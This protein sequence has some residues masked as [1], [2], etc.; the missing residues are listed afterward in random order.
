M[1]FVW[2]WEQT[3]IISLY[4]INWLVFIIETEC[5]YCAVRTG[6]LYVIQVFCFSVKQLT[7]DIFNS[8]FPK[9]MSPCITQR[10]GL[11]IPVLLRGNRG[12]R[13][14]VYWNLYLRE[15][16]PNITNFTY[17]L[18]QHA[19]SYNV[20]LFPYTCRGLYE[21]HSCKSSFP[22][23][24]RPLFYTHLPSPY[25]PF[26]SIPLSPL[27]AYLVYVGPYEFSAEM[28]CMFLK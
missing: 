17:P 13:K 18:L 10:V 15:A 9:G 21:L 27:Y 12:G 24:F 22:V 7:Y 19:S 11:F 2:I 25:P 6:S 3:A 26:L 8:K 1:C 5:F 4:R 20:F 28:L 23:Y 14:E 16:A